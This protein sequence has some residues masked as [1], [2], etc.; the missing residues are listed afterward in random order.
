MQNNNINNIN[1]LNVKN[2][3]LKMIFDKFLL[4]NSFVSITKKVKINVDLNAEIKTLINSAYDY[5]SDNVNKKMLYFISNVAT[6]DK[7]ILEDTM[8]NIIMNTIFDPTISSFTFK[9]MFENIKIDVD[10]NA[11]FKSFFP[12]NLDITCANKMIHFL[13]S[14]I[15]VTS[16]K[17]ND[18]NKKFFT[19]TD[20]TLGYKLN[21]EKIRIINELVPIHNPTMTENDIYNIFLVDLFSYWKMRMISSSY[22]KNCN[23]Q[24][25]FKYSCMHIN[26]D[27]ISLILNHKI[28]P[29]EIHL[30]YL[31]MNDKNSYVIK[32][33]DNKL[34]IERINFTILNQIIELFLSY[35]LMLTSSICEILL[36]NKFHDILIKYNKIKP[37][38]I[39]D[40]KGLTNKKD[41]IFE[42]LNISKMYNDKY[43][44]DV[45]KQNMLSTEYT[46]VI[47]Y[48]YEKYGIIPTVEQ[49]NKLNDVGRQFVIKKR[50]NLL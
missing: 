26:I 31:L 11:Y 49:I 17:L 20:I 16:K 24:L 47:E 42:I 22:L 18:E 6:N 8:F 21:A 36:K 4:F 9:N 10:I 44:I 30:I 41:K 27:A 3:I 43:N 40:I 5:M 14:N 45:I 46:G 33:I 39:K 7:T 28:I 2:I 50:F 37:V 48:A 1:T 32:N 19:T 12:I 15:N 29:E 25:L 34:Y 38:D 13:K 23:M 35:G